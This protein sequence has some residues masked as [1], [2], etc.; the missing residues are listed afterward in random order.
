MRRRHIWKKGAFWLPLFLCLGTIS[1]SA[2]ELSR[3]EA[4]WL[5]R[6]V[7]QNEC[8]SRKA[9]LTAW[10]KGEDF[11]SLGIGHFIWYPEAVPTSEKRFDE[12][13]PEL[14][15]WMQRKNIAI[16]AWLRH[17]HGN[18]WRNRQYF[19][20]I[21]HTARM[22][23][24]RDFLWQT[25]AI[26]AEFMQHRLTQALPRM[27]DTLPS[28]QQKHIQQQ[29]K[30]VANSPMG[31]Y[32]LIDYVNFKGEGI[33]QSERY[34]GKGWGLLQVLQHMHSKEPG[35]ATVQA[36]ADSASFVL[37]RRV[38]LSPATRHEERWLAGWKKRVQS[39]AN[40]AADY[41][42]GILP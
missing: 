38:R 25:R 31:F 24:L 22:Q 30:L 9:C 4:A 14:L 3:D 37:T 5:G 13:F 2:M 1:T 35:I 28:T 29:F 15:S 8:A 18:P 6:L 21:I 27:L 19:H 10:N 17:Q 23:E 26:Q 32:A 12:S 41:E 36:F 33:K 16:P 20:S 34:Q 40:A 42:K 11:A 39:Y 7:F